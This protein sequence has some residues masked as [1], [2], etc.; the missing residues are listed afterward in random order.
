MGSV[1]HGEDKCD[2]V[3]YNMEDH[4]FRFVRSDACFKILEKMKPSIGV[5][6]TK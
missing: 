3:G 4:T 1:A 2:L 5:K 6:N